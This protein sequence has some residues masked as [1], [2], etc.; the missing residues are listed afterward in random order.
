MR[1]KKIIVWILCA[2]ASQI[3]HYAAAAGLPGM[4]TNQKIETAIRQ[5][6]P[7]Q[8]ERPALQSQ[9]QNIEAPLHQPEFVITQQP[10][11]SFEDMDPGEERSQVFSIWNTGEEEETYYL[12]IQLS[13]GITWE[14]AKAGTWYCSGQAMQ[15]PLKLAQLQPKD[16][17]V[18]QLT[19]KNT[20]N[21]CGTAVPVFSGGKP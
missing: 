3:M 20:E 9:P 17:V 15:T 21:A 8:T 19:V 10:F 12:T 6:S 1:R 7:Q 16:H 2:A 14:L 18:F 4:G 11:L 5:E 13:E